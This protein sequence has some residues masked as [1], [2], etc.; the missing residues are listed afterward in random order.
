MASLKQCDKFH[1]RESE[2]KRFTSGGWEMCWVKSC[3]ICFKC[4]VYRVDG[5]DG[6]QSLGRNKLKK[7]MDENSGILINS[8]YKQPFLYCR[9]RICSH[10]QWH[11]DGSFF[12]STSDLPRLSLL[13]PHL[14]RGRS[15][16]LGR[17][18]TK[19]FPLRTNF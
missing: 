7:L 8:F 4:D 1:S 11:S 3:L 10:S 12:S 6:K 18:I 14:R 19:L 2:R 15:F 13:S 9:T 17:S 16:P 5:V